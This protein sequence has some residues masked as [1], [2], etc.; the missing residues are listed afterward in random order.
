VQDKLLSFICVKNNV[1]YI[2]F[3]ANFTILETFNTEGERG[4]DIRDVLY[5]LVGFEDL[6]LSKEKI[7]IP[8]IL[9]KEHYY[10]LFIEPFCDNN[11]CFIA[12][13]QQRSLETQNYANLLQKINK[14]TLLYDTS[15]AKKEGEYFNEINKR[16][17]TLHVNLDGRIT[18]INDAASHFFN[19]EASAMKGKHF[20]EFFIPQSTEANQKHTIF[21]AK[22]SFGE[23]RFFHADVIAL[24]NTKEEIEENIILLQDISYLKSIEKKLQYAQEHDTLTNLPNRHFLLKEIDR[25][26]LNSSTVTVA[27]LDLVGFSKINEEYG[28]HAGDMYIKH[29]V[30]IIQSIIEPKDLLARLFADH[31]VILFEENKHQNYITVLLQK[32]EDSLKQ[33]PLLYTQ[34]DTIST[35]VITTISKIPEDANSAK[36]LLESLEKKLSK[37]KITHQ[38][39]L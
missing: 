38:L 18:R 25:R 27:L 32:I 7:E 23:R 2:L 36:D 33:K 11:N 22:D 1:S 34:E 37:I 10:D 8:M 30:D 39:S 13:M 31:F 29:F 14:K 20:S 5:E 24:K 6:I 4:I 3:D 21:T 19:L 35:T 9:R 17:I 16:L 26:L 12:Y 28:S 15:D